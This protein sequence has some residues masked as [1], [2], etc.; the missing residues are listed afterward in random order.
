MIEGMTRVHYTDGDFAKITCGEFATFGFNLTKKK[1]SPRQYRQEIE[2]WAIRRFGDFEVARKFINFAMGSQRLGD[3]PVSDING[4]PLRYLAS[5]NHEQMTAQVRSD[6][7]NLAKKAN[8][9]VEKAWD[10]L[11]IIMP[12]IV[13][14]R[15]IA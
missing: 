3:E 8:I 10:K 13:Q 6:V 11:S 15:P 9:T 2:L 4:L 7:A 12:D 5:L 1:I 14:Y